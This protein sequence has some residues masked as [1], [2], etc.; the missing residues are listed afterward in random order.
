[1]GWNLS[2]P[3]QDGGLQR[4]RGQ[5]AMDHGLPMV[6]LAQERRRILSGIKNH[7][8]LLVLGP[9]GS[10]KTRLIASALAESGEQALTVE[11]PQ[12]LRQLLIKLQ[13]ALFEQPVAPQTSVRLKGVIWSAL[14]AAPALIVLD[15]IRTASNPTYRFLQRLFYTKGMRLIA[16]A[17]DRR[18]LQELVRLFWDPR[19]TVNVNPLTETESRRLFELAADSFRLRHLDLEDFRDRTLKVARGNPGQIVEMCRLAA[20]PQ[21]VSGNRVKFA[22]LRID[23]MVKFLR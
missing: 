13:R 9:A 7:E 16:A 23:A 6:G 22:P 19:F 18:C 21:Y 15:D 14:E 2:K 17:R 20:Q 4:A 11:C 8:S 12:A 3:H 10:G 1:M 5:V